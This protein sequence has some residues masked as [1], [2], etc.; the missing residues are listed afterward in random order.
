[1]QQ[2]LTTKDNIQ[3]AYEVH[4]D[5]S[6]P[7]DLLVMGLGMPSIAWPKSF[8]EGLVRQGLRVITFDNRDSGYSTKISENVSKFKILRAIFRT[9]ARKHV[10][11]PYSLEDM[12]TDAEAVLD[13]LGI[14]RAHVLGVS[15]GGMIAQ[16]MAL[17]YPQRVASLISV[18]SASGNPSTGLGSFNAVRALLKKPADEGDV[19]SVA[20]YFK[21]M[22]KVIG[23][24]Q[25]SYDEELIRAVAKSVV[26]S[27]YQFSAASRQL[28]AILASGDRS[29]TLCRIIAPTLV[30]HGRRDPLLPFKAGEEV[31]RNIPNSRML[32]IDGMGHDLPDRVIEQIVKEVAKH[33][34]RY[35]E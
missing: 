18:M 21:A 15:M 22:F 32:G 7:P 1:M 29:K 34:H 8:I 9:L 27:G 2:F 5:E 13:T 31:A 30:I 17:N 6:A 23:S 4:G 3:I 24:P 33:C 16:V 28:L 19:E 14:S 26:Q 11:A 35:K 20:R 25:G 10:S 12:A